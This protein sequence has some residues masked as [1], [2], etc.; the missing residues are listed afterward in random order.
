[1]P[2]LFSLLCD[3][4]NE[5]DQ[6]RMKKESKTINVQSH[7]THTTVA[8]FNKHRRIIPREGPEAVA[9]LSCLFP[10]RRADRVFNLQEKRLES[11]I[12]QAQGLGVTRLKQLQNWRTRDG[13]DFASCVE[14][15]MSATDS[16]P[17]PGSSVTLEELDEI[18]DRI[19]ATSSF[20][21]VDLRERIEA[22][23]AEPIRTQDALST[24]FRRLYS[25]EAKW[26]VRM[27]LKTYSP[28]Q[29]PET[30]AMQQ[31][32][33]LLPD[34]LC[35]QKSF[36]AAVMCGTTIKRMPA[37]P[38]KDVEVLLRE[39]AVRKL[40]PQVGV[41]ITRPAHEKAISKEEASKR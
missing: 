9:F 2:F 8:W 26:M 37:H 29:I 39:I 10:E 3:L 1:M 18:L 40:T 20:S 6:D 33:F 11:I 12:K 24:I 35:F 22:K 23:Y 28:V 34:L 7:H 16:E 13:A 30:L 27:I 31:F 5:L 36:E 4:L 25:S 15:V 32:H 38:A 14:R 21:S 41:M 19:A 17:R